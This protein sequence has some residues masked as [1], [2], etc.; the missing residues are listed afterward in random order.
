MKYVFEKI[1]SFK[2]INLKKVL[3]VG[4]GLGGIS[5]YLPNG[6]H[7]YY[8]DQDKKIFQQLPKRTGI[9]FHY[10]ASLETAEKFDLIFCNQVLEHVCEPFSFLNQIGSL[11]SSHG[12][13]YLE[14]PNS[15]YNFKEDV[16]PH[17]LFFTKNSLEKFLLNQGWEIIE[18][19]SFG[20]LPPSKNSLIGKLIYKI[21]HFGFKLGWHRLSQQC[22]SNMMRLNLVESKQAIWLSALIQKKI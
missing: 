14:V 4:A 13:I 11:L 5:Y 22:Y 12:M 19:R 6:T 20:N 10:M 15:D 21:M 7:Y 1:L 17:V 2:N 3:D 18:I 16:F 9:N 8:Q